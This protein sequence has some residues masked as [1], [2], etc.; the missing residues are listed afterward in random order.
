MSECAFA[1]RLS[2]QNAFFCIPES[3]FARHLPIQMHS[4]PAKTSYRSTPVDL[5]KS[6]SCRARFPA[7]HGRLDAA[8]ESRQL[9]RILACLAALARLGV[10]PRFARPKHLA[11]LGR[12]TALPR[13]ARPGL[14]L[15]VVKLCGCR[16]RGITCPAA[17]KMR[18]RLTSGSPGACPQAA[19]IGRHWTSRIRSLGACPQAARIGHRWTSQ[20]R[21]PGACPMAATVGR[22]WTSQ[23]SL[24]GCLSNGGRGWTTLDKSNSLSGRLSTGGQDWTPMD[25]SNSLAFQRSEASK[26]YKYSGLSHTHSQH[27]S[28]R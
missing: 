19:R 25:K 22:R 27:H 7:D 2:I 11:S 20:T 6:R 5:N 8:V 24:S 13:F 17:S 18:G 21:F 15:Q 14:A 9:N 12:V 4:V 3:A 26:H 16:I 1:R 10:T 28:A 23:I